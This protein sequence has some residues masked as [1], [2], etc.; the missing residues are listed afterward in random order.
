MLIL[1]T[2]LVC[3]LFP[4]HIW[5]CGGTR[6]EPRNYTEEFGHFV[7]AVLTALTGTN[8]LEGPR[9]EHQVSL[10]LTDFELFKRHCV[11][12]QW[13][14]LGDLWVDVTCL[15]SQTFTILAAHCFF[16]V[17]PW[18]GSASYLCVISGTDDGDDQIL[19]IQPHSD[20]QPSRA[21]GEPQQG[22]S[23]W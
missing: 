21:V 11:D 18:V 2:L 15:V 4:P 5:I 8:T 19:A 23:S 20:G 16:H 6:L 10:Q 17:S 7:A 1:G 9:E 22:L 13:N 12:D 3:L 14:L